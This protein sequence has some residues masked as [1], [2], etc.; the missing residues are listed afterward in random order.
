MRGVHSDY[1]RIPWQLYVISYV[2]N[3]YPLTRFLSHKFQRKLADTAEMTADVSGFIYSDQ[4]LGISS[5]TYAVILQT[6]REI[7]ERNLSRPL[8]SLLLHIIGLLTRAIQSRVVSA[9]VWILLT[10]GILGVVAFWIATSPSLSELAP[11]LTADLLL[12]LY[13]LARKRTSRD[14]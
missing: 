3:D 9:V 13:Q 7:S 12:V 14:G 8:P 11:A 1:I 10:F 6:C 5:R 2:A 4:T